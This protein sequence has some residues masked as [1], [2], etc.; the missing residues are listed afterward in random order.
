MTRMY[1]FATTAQ[2]KLILFCMILFG[3]CYSCKAPISNE[4]KNFSVE[5]LVEEL[6]GLLEKSAEVEFL[7]EGFVWSEGPVWLPEQQ[8]LLFTDVPENKIYEWSEITGLKVWLEPSG[9]TGIYEDGGKQ[10]GN[11]LYLDTEGKLVIAQHGD[12]RIVRFAGNFDNPIPTFAVL[13]DSFEGQRYNSPNDLYIDKVGNIYFTDPP[14]GLPNQDQ[15]EAKDLS[16][17]GVFVL[18]TDGEV[19]LLDN[20]LTRPNGIA[21]DE[22]RNLLYVANSDSQRA[23]WMKYTLDD[24]GQIEKRDFFAD[25]TD[26]LSEKEGLP[27]GLKIHSSGM[28][29]ATGPGGVLVFHPDG[30]HLGTIRT[31]HKVANCAFDHKEEYLYMTSHMYLCRIKMKK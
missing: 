29:F 27:D 8:K 24:A 16:F 30:R 13:T 23:F 28:I 5:I 1:N 4:N 3:L 19:R 17:N 26:A 2:N 15:D 25:M 6:E 9:Y 31:G 18:L 20:T 11:G 21:L 7:A 10:G 22:K 12:R 14:Y